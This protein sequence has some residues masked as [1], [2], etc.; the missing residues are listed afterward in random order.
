MSSNYRFA[1]LL[2]LVSI[3]S[4][5]GTYQK[6]VC[7]TM[8]NDAGIRQHDKIN[9]IIIQEANN[10][11]YDIKQIYIK[12]VK[13]NNY[14]GKLFMH[15]NTT[16]GTDIFEITYKNNEVCMFGGGSEARADLA[17]KEILNRLQNLKSQ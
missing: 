17:V 14:E 16:S 12:P 4:G 9:K 2:S 10:N 13:N 5:C 7:V 1:V 6:K 3:L 11:G 8:L 15:H